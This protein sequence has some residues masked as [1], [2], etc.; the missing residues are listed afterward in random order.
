MVAC[1]RAAERRKRTPEPGPQVL[2]RDFNSRDRLVWRS[3]PI[4]AISQE[5]LKTK[6][7]AQIL[8]EHEIQLHANLLGPALYKIQ[9][10]G[11]AARARLGDQSPP[12]DVLRVQC[13]ERLIGEATQQRLKQHRHD[14]KLLKAIRRLLGLVEPQGAPESNDN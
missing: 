8:E 7:M 10:R 9:G 14:P 5:D 2:G 13:I 4:E 6:L 12:A 11:M 1:Q 3:K